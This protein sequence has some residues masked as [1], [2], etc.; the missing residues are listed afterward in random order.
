MRERMEENVRHLE[1]EIE[2]LKRR[3][4]GRAFSPDQSD[5]TQELGR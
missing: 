5:N 4:V 1:S 3:Q 2:C